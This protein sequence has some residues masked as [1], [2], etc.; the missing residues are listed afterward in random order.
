MI[1]REATENEI[2]AHNKQVRSQSATAHYMDQ[3]YKNKSITSSDTGLQVKQ[4][5]DVH[6]QLP[7]NMKQTIKSGT[8]ADQ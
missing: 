4:K 8:T 2:R 3:L 7:G 1:I 5:P 6:K